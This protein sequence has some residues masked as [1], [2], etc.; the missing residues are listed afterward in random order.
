[1]LDTTCSLFKIEKFELCKG[2]PNA[3]S[4]LEQQLRNEQEKLW[5]EI[6]FLYF[7]KVIL[8]S[9]KE[10]NITPLGFAYVW[11]AKLIVMEI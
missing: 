6:K 4:K 9:T 10:S 5:L 3:N 2:E 8:E 7:I 11:H 1:M